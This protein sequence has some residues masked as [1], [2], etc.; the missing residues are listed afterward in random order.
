MNQA[1]TPGGERPLLDAKGDQTE[2]APTGF[3]G[4]VQSLGVQRIFTPEQRELQMFN[5]LLF[6]RKL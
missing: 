4:L 2:I 5:H 3:K 6:H 1:L